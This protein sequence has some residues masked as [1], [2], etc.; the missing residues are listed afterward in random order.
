M[1]QKGTDRAS[2]RMNGLTSLYSPDTRIKT[3]KKYSNVIAAAR[4]LSI[5]LFLLCRD[6]RVEVTTTPP[7]TVHI[8]SE[9]TNRRPSREANIIIRSSCA[10]LSH[11]QNAP[12]LPLGYSA[13]FMRDLC[14]ESA[15]V[16]LTAARMLPRLVLVMAGGW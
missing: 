11:H 15:L 8:T 9:M 7:R 14:R 12:L 3:L 16:T 1:A 6:G 2:T 10:L 13:R 5:P 4:C